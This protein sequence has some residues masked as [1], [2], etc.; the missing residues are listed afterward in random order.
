M[1]QEQE[2]ETGIEYREIAA[3]DG[4]GVSEYKGMSPQI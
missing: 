4:G 2:R 1:Q 3:E